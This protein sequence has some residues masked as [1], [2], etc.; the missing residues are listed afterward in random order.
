VF[1]SNNRID[2]FENINCV[3]DCAQLAELALDGNPIHTKKGY[4]E[5]IL[6]MCSNLK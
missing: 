6:K 3:K 4:A 2:K 1:L 5:Q